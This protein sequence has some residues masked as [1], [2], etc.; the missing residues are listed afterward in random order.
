[1]HE[2]QSKGAI[3]NFSRVVISVEG[4][5]LLQDKSLMWTFISSNP[6]PEKKKKRNN[7]SLPTTTVFKGA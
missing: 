5:L 2:M 4:I 6:Q 3:S 7:L 1:M